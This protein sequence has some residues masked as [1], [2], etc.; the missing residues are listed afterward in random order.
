MNLN[1]ADY[2]KLKKDF[3]WYANFNQTSSF[4]CFINVMH[5]LKNKPYLFFVITSMHKAISLLENARSTHA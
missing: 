4:V 5:G 3:R 1:T 2:L